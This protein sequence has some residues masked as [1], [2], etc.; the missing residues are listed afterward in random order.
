MAR[1]LMRLAL[2]ESVDDAVNTLVFYAA[3]GVS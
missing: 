3:A 1:Q 2:G